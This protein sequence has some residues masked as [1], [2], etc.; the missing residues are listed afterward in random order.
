M[1]KLIP[2]LFLFS[3]TA[4]KTSVIVDS[5]ASYIT[6]GNGKGYFT[7]WQWSR[8]GKVLSTK[9]YDTLTVQGSGTFTY[10]FTI[11]DNLGQTKSESKTITVK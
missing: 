2:L 5:Q 4:A 11:T 6:G 9:P 7:A 1:I 8:N 3:C 10:T